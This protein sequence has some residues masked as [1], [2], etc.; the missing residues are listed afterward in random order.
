MAALTYQGTIDVF[1][2]ETVSVHSY[3]SPEAGEFVRSQIIETPHS[4]IVVDVQLSRQYAAEVRRYAE[5]LGKPISRVIISHM[6][7]DHWL[8]IDAF[9]DLPLY[10]LSEVIGHLEMLGDFWIG[11]K[12]EELGD[13]IPDQKVIPQHVLQE[14]EEVID[15]VKFVFRKVTQAECLA[16]LMIELPE[17]KTLLP[18]DLVYNN[19]HLFVGELHG[20]NRDILC[21][22]GW[23]KTLEQLKTEDFEL[24][25][26]GHGDPT[27]SSVFDRSIGFLKDAQ[28]VFETAKDHQEFKARLIE[29]YPHYKLPMLLDM[30]VLTLYKLM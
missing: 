20:E 28:Q 6:H 12:K 10:A 2:G 25:I 7:P 5:S 23:I 27:D 9:K 17:V 21:F 19:I 13:Q 8:G 16:N 15:G 18:Q 3:S 30:S 22:D 29:L 1:R 4:L 26:P 14:G 11:L 24:V